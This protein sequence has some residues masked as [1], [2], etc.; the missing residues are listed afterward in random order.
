[1]SATHKGRKLERTEARVHPEQKTRS[2]DMASLHGTLVSDFMVQSADEAAVRTIRE[3]EVWTLQGRDREIFVET[4]LN[5]PA[6]NARVKTAV[7][8]YKKLSA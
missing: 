4:L 2:E 6:P 5:P 8:R 3:H 7:A 1:M